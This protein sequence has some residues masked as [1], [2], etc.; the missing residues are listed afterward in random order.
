MEQDDL[1]S[2]IENP[3]NSAHSVQESPVSQPSFQMIA[4]LSEDL[5]PYKKKRSAFEIMSLIA[6]V[7][8]GA[9]GI[10]ILVLFILGFV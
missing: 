1:I 10:F 5:K 3:D 4:P 6:Y 2:S 9:A 7:I 8:L